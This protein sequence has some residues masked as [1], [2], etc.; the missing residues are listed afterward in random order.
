[1]GEKGRFCRMSLDVMAGLGPAIPE[2]QLVNPR[3]KLGDD[4]E[5]WKPV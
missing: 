5:R 3:A 4:S 2:N 1:M